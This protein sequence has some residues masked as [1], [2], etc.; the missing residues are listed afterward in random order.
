MSEKKTAKKKKSTKRDRK[1]RR[2]LPT[3]TPTSTY[4]GIG[5]MA[6]ALALGAGVY[7]QWIREP[8]YPWAQYLVAGGALTLGAALWFSDVTGDPVRV[9]DAGVAL[10]QGGEFLRVAWC[11][12]TRIRIDR[13]KLLLETDDVTMAIPIAG[14]QAT[15]AWI[16]KQAV[17]R[18]PD[19]LDVKDRDSEGLPEPKETDGELVPVENLQIAGRACAASEKTIAFERDARLCP[20]C[21][22]VYDKEH[23]PRN[24]VTCGEELRGH[25]YAL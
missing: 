5:G 20:T 7:G 11:D 18:V 2:F 16:L 12:L 25:A 14:H 19:A 17:L 9:G 3:T 22:Q 23:V 15:V 8:G 1:E 4:A 13:A 6:G 10:E 21:A 24:C